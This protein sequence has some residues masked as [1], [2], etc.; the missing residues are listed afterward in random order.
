M[1]FNSYEFIFL[2]LPVT[3]IVYFFLNKKRMI[4]ASN[5][6]LLLA[7]FFF[8]SWWN[9]RFLPLLC[10][11]ILFNYAI[12]SFLLRNDSFKRI[13]FAKKTVF[14]TGIA[15]NI[16]LLIYFK[17]MNFFISNINAIFA[18][19]NKL[20]YIV[21]PLGISFFTITQIIFLIDSY[22]GNFKKYNLLNYALFICFFPCLFAGPILNHREIIPQFESL[23][24]KIINYK[25]LSLGILLFSIGLFKKVVIADSLGKW[26]NIGFDTAATL[27]LFEAWITSLSYTFQLYF[28]FSGYSEM[29]IGLGLMFN[30]K[31]PVNFNSPF[32][33]VSI[34]DFWKRWH[35]T[36]TNFIMNYIYIP[37]LWSFKD[38]NFI[39]S[40]IAI[41]IAM[42]ICGLWHGAAWTFVIWG[43]IHGLAIIA[44]HCWR[45]SKFKMP[46][47]LGWFITFNFVNFSMVIFR[48]KEWS[49]AV[50]VFKGM[51]GFNGVVLPEMFLS[52]L[53]S[54]KNYGVIFYGD[55]LHNVRGGKATII[56]IIL[57]S[58]IAFLFKNSMEITEKF[59]PDWFWAFYTGCLLLFGIIFTAN[60]TDFLYFQF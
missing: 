7:S 26:A 51:L 6:W 34:I 57:V 47:L 27:N 21:F 20:L 17:Y 44:N 13:F 10:G 30:I 4:I 38:K 1:L 43:T 36:L 9:I 41:L 49:D 16:L 3:V 58:I 39:K 22:D 11:S 15:G 25:S 8:Y 23:R 40:M 14:V 53:A 33:A 45:K 55:Y 35:I 48:A 32:K 52:F 56:T 12:G 37:I 29:A 2:F 18:V 19:D 54:L 50:K 24:K 28:D 42:L 59:K 31:L 46:N 5:V 60:K